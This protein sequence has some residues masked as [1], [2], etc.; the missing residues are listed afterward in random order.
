MAI[1]FEGSWPHEYDFT[2][3]HLKGR[4]HENADALSRMYDKGDNYIDLEF[5]EYKEYKKLHQLPTMKNLTMRRG[6]LFSAPEEWALA[7]CLSKN[8]AM[9]AGIARQFK[10]IYGSLDILTQQGLPER[11]LYHVV[12]KDQ[13]W[14][15][16]SYRTLWNALRQLKDS[17]EKNKDH[18]LAM[19][20]I[21]CGLDKLD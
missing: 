6:S 8:F 1:N 7:H 5:E 19:P 12:T 21:E 17:C 15:K 13:F 14:A 16:P 20:K 10:E 3:I 11:N 4:L 9:G 18:R 2:I